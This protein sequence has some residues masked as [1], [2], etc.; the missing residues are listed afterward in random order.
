LLEDAKK[1]FVH[2]NC[3]IS[4]SLLT[5]KYKKSLNPY[6]SDAVVIPKPV[7]DDLRLLKTALFMNEDAKMIVQVILSENDG[8]DYSSD[9]FKEGDRFEN[10]ISTTPSY[11]PGRQSYNVSDMLHSELFYVGNLLCIPNSSEHIL[12][13][14][15]SQIPADKIVYED[16]IMESLGCESN[17]LSFDSL[18]SIKDMLDSTDA[19]TV[20]A[21][22]KSLSMMD[23]MHYANSVKY[24]LQMASKTN[25]IYNKAADST[26]V[27]YMLRTLSES[28]N[29]RRWPGD[30][31]HSIYEQDFELFK[32]L[33]MHYDNV[34]EDKILENI[35][36]VSFMT[37]TFD[38]ILR[39]NIKKKA[40]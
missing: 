18:T 39:P 34:S 35:R 38:G 11:L 33:K 1:V 31:D 19:N 10:L 26:S 15:T 36:F 32:Q 29:R 3:K 9:N 12:D 16:S 28:S 17:Q 22:L 14:L 23:W 6:L 25:W 27:K 30:F 7:Y 21:G 13:I 24:I 5:E 40:V 2:Q 4:R 37:V 20:S 8:T